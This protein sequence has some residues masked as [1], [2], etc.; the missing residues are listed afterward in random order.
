MYT[1]QIKHSTPNVIE[2]VALA[3]FPDLGYVARYNTPLR[4][5]YG[6]Q[7]NPNYAIFYPRPSGVSLPQP[8]PG[9]VPNAPPPVVGMPGQWSSGITTTAQYP[10]GANPVTAVMAP[11]VSQYAGYRMAYMHRNRGVAGISDYI[12]SGITGAWEDIK[13]QVS[14]IGTSQWFGYASIGLGALILWSV[15]GSLTG[16]K[17]RR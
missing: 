17:R 1:P 14:S 12:P 13:G 6:T 5:R 3:G 15:A 11:Q 16:K 9:N 2:G 10:A 8:L 4:S 7:Y